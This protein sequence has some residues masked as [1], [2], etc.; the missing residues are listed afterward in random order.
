LLYEQQWKFDALKNLLLSFKPGE[1]NG[2]YKL[3]YELSSRFFHNKLQLHLPVH[4]PGARVFSLSNQ[5]KAAEKLETE[6]AEVYKVEFVVKR[7]V[8]SKLQKRLASGLGF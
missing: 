8:F 1:V 4:F 3:V 2:E 5:Y 6:V 7:S